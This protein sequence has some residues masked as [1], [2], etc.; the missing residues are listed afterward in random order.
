MRISKRREIQKRIRNLDVLLRSE[1]S[2]DEGLREGEK[3][4]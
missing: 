3:S 1:V 2:E 4:G